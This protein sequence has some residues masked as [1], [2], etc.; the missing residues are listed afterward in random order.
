MYKCKLGT[1]Y[2]WAET[3]H[4]KASE[5][6]GAGPAYYVCKKHEH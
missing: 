5:E 3:K 1:V 2:I 4:T 6:I